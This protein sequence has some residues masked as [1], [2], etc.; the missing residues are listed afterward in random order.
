[1][2]GDMTR[3]RSNKEQEL[4]GREQQL[5]HEMITAYQGLKMMSRIMKWIVF[6]L[7][8]LVIDLARLMEA[9]DNILTHLKRWLTKS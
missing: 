9:L 5:L 7:F 1:M 6:F 3:K 8:L 4:T 2:V